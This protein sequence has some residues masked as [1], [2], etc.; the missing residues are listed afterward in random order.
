MNKGYVLFVVKKHGLTPGFL[1]FEPSTSSA[2]TWHYL[3]P[4]VTKA[5]V[6]PIYEAAEAVLNSIKDDDRYLCIKIFDSDGNPCQENVS[7]SS[8]NSTNTDLH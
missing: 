6:Y 3:E 4:D 5:T 8:I 2:L 1:R 7:F